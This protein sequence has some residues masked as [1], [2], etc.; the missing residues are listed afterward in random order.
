MN[1]AWEELHNLTGNYITIALSIFER[2]EK[3]QRS[4]EP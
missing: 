2:L 3:S 1:F 4:Q